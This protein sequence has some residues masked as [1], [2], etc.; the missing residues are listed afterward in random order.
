MKQP[1]R[2]QRG[3]YGNGHVFEGHGAWYLQYYQN[4]KRETIRLADRD[5]IHTSANC[6]AIR[7]LRQKHMMGVTSSPNNPL[8]KDMRVVEYWEQRFIPYCEEIVSVGPRAGQPRK[9]PST[10]KGYRQVWRQFLLAHL[11]NCTLQ[12]YQPRMGKQLLRSLT[13]TQGFHV[14]KHIKSLGSAIFQLALDD[15][16]V[17]MNP[18]Y[19]VNMPKDAIQPADTPHYTREQSEDLVSALVD[20]V[21]AQLVLALAC[22]LAL[23]PAEIAGLRWEDIDKNWIHIRRNVVDGEVGTPKTKERAAPV[24]LIDEVRVPLELWCKKCDN[25]VDGWLFGDKPVDLHNLVAR[26]IRP[27]VDGE[28]YQRKG[29]PQTCKRCEVVPKASRVEWRGMYT[30]RRGAITHTIEAS[31]GNFALGQALARHASGKTTQDFYNK[32]IT[33]KAFLEGMKQLKGK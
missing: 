7:L 5:S 20:H 23:G 16:I 2:K 30:A 26:V 27:H 4:G 17:T 13:A 24:P 33:P 15:E 12:K 9:K 32:G 18:W 3:T 1:T 22:F 25:P 10:M 11:G 28:R 6:K 21:D 14:L 31:N 8:A 29:E 19:N